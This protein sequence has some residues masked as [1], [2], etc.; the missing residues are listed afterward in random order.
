MVGAKITCGSLTELRP[1]RK[2]ESDYDKLFGSKPGSLNFT[3]NTT[4]LFKRLL[5]NRVL[6]FF[7]FWIS[8]VTQTKEQ[9]SWLLRSHL[10][11]F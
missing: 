9:S 7:G 3:A 2:E 5:H 10:L 4:E 8:H 11:D 6:N 1:E